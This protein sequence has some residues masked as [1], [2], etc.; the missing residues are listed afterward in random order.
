MSDD[1]ITISKSTG[2]NLD[3][4]SL[5]NFDSRYIC[6]MDGDVYLIKDEL[7]KSYKVK[8][9]RPF[10]T[11]DGYVEFVLTEKAGT[12]RHIQAHRL[13]GFLYL[14]K[15]KDKN[16]VNHKDGNKENNRYT[17]LVWMT[18]KENIQHTYDELGRVAWNKGKTL[19]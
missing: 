6:T 18:Q 9:M 10:I 4:L 7:D 5:Y 3:K 11:R 16:Y 17:N 15:P 2:K 13:V 8:Q 12:K 14:I 19:K 1:L